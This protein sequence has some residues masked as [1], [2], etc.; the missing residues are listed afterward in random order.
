MQG[1]TKIVRIK[2]LLRLQEPK[3]KLGEQPQ[4]RKK[5]EKPVVHCAAV[6]RANITNGRI[7]SQFEWSGWVYIAIASESVQ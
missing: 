4:T 2:D 3:A 7:A 1:E 6:L 5:G